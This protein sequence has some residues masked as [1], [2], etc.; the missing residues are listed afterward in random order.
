MTTPSS[1][2]TVLIADDQSLIRAGFAMVINSQSD[3]TVVGEAADGKVA[4]NMVRQLKPDVVLMDVR[5][6]VEDGISATEEITAMDAQ[7]DDADRTT[8]VIILTT[9]D[10]DEYVMS[11]IR[12]GASGF[13]LK[14][15]SPEDMLSSIRTVHQGNAII[16]PSATK[17]L[18]EKLIV[19]PDGMS[20]SGSQQ[21]PMLQGLTAGNSISSPSAADEKT[22][23]P[24]AFAPELESLTEREREVLIEIAHGLSNQEIADKLYVSLPTVKT[25][26]AH[27]LAKINARDRVQAVVFAYEAGLV[28]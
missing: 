3:M 20:V 28:S 16:A 14:D 11:A 24:S 13:L 10:L 26:V 2:I 1:P 8:R 22:S 15:T 18:I 7:T 9:F 17:R 12:A 27:L 5:M 4:V 25:H 19:A 21:S 23:S 6:P